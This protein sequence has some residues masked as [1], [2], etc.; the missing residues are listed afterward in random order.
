MRYRDTLLIVASALCVLNQATL[1]Q[2]RWTTSA[3]PTVEI[4]ATSP[5]GDVQFEFAASATRLPSG[6]IVVAEGSAGALRV[7][8]AS[9]RPARTVGRRGAGPGEFQYVS[10]I[11]QCGDTVVAWDFV[12]RRFSFLN[13][14][15]RVIRQTAPVTGAIPFTVA[16]SRRASL[17]AAH[18][19]GSPPRPGTAPMFRY[20][21]PLVFLDHNATIAKQID[22]VA[23]GEMAIIGGGAGP[24]PL[25]KYTHLAMSSTALYV[26]TGDSAVIQVYGHSGASLGA[27]RTN[28]ARAEPSQRQVD[29]A[30]EA[31]IAFGP[32]PLRDRLRPAMQALERPRQLPPF[33]GLLVDA[34]DILWVVL[35]FP[36]EGATRLRALDSQGG[37]LGEVHIP[38][39]LRVF[40]IGRDYILGLH[41]TAEGEQFIRLYELRRA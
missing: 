15:A 16:C 24:R 21:A 37:T 30:I 41:E 38:A 6:E 23:S 27:I 33:S 14:S 1:S 28:V 10:W 40:E 22:S 39:D 12:Q 19:W 2:P 9:G 32:K 36:G 29:L 4:A 11:G 17:I 25:G 35:S 26:S 3:T 31:A 5:V 7:F 13:D 8:N 20:Q 18:A 34:L